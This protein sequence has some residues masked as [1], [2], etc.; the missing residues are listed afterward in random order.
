MGMGDSKPYKISWEFM[1]TGYDSND[2]GY[3]IWWIPA[4]SGMF[5]QLDV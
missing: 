1:G 5:F 4:F 3:G 2:M